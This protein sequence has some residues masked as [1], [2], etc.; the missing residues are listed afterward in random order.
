MFVIALAGPYTGT[1]APV[2]WGMRLVFGTLAA[3]F[4]LWLR[5]RLQELPPQRPLSR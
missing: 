1:E 2:A 4:A 5:S 3:L